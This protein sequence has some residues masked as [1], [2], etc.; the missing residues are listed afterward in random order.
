MFE[1]LCLGKNLLLQVINSLLCVKYSQIGISSG[2]L[3]TNCSCLYT[4]RAAG[5]NITYVGMESIPMGI[6]F[7]H[8]HDYEYT[9]HARILKL[10]M[11]VKHSMQIK[12][13]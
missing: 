3:V 4:D 1:N 6:K 13:N 10:T 9:D 5:I 8:T 11:Q 2:Y 12:K 7:I